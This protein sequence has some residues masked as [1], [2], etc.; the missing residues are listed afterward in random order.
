MNKA[1]LKSYAPQAHGDFIQIQ[2]RLT[3]AFYHYEK[4]K[5]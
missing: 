5:V 3:L 2:V 4:V 1:E